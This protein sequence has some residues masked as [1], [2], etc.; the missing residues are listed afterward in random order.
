MAIFANSLGF[1]EPSIPD[2]VPFLRTQIGAVFSHPSF[3]L[4]YP[5]LFLLVFQAEFDLAR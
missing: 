2:F 1:G 4:P 3:F 5:A